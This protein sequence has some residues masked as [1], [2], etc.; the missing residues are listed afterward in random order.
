V[1]VKLLLTGTALNHVSDVLT[2]KLT[3]PPWE[4]V[5]LTG[6]MEVEFGATV[7]EKLVGLNVRGPPLLLVLPVT[8]TA[9]GICTEPFVVPPALTVTVPL[10]KPFDRFVGSTWIVHNHDVSLGE[11]DGVAH[12]TDEDA[13]IAMLVPSLALIG[14]PTGPQPCWPGT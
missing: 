1:V 9:I 12:V 6:C 5:T 4:L 10:F 3:F 13:E 14:K 8:S 11:H 2:L 7:G